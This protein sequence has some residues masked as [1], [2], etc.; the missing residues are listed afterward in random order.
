M[1]RTGGGKRG[2]F[3]NGE[4]WKGGGESVL[5]VDGLKAC[6]ATERLAAESTA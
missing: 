1:R 3:S 2:R 5:L 6:K 4:Y